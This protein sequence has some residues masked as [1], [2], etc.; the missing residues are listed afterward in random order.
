MIT[1]SALKELVDFDGQGHSVLSVYLNTDLTQHSKEE[2]RLALKQMLE[3]LREG[4][5][6]V[7]RVTKFFDQKYD[8]QSKGVA[9][10]T[11]AS[12]KFWR[13]LRLAVPVLDYAS[14]DDKPNVRLL[15][16]LLDEYERYAVA[17]V[18]R[19]HARFFVMQLGEIEEF[20]Y[21][22]PATPGR[23][24]QGGWSAARY[25]R[26]IETLALQNL[27][28]A[29]QLTNDFFKSQN[30]SRLLLA[31]TGDTLAQFR[32]LLPK[33][34]RESIAGEFPLDIETPASRVLSKARE[35]QERVERAHELALVEQVNTAA[36]KKRPTA[37]LG[38][39]DTLNALMER[40]VYT[41]VVASDW[42]TKGFA[43]DHCG[44]LSAQRL[45]T[46]PLC[47]HSM[48]SVDRIVDLAVRRA[49]E[50]GSRVELVHASAANKLKEWGGI[51]ALLRY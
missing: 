44:Y 15:T 13:E 49:I 20:A 42:R 47:S 24:K 34:L 21:E 3:P 22:L 1:P 6:D 30:C 12:L 46:C 25:Q 27:K 18:D 14:V 9:V 17:L 35:I 2:R 23:H 8:W 37:T 48:R 31:G 29:A 26:H 32:G 39:A 19:D 5:A 40:A 41:L 45:A 51:G 4:G 38:L 50:L 16:D 28:Q 36:R 7:T 33:P 43:C 11:C 10:F